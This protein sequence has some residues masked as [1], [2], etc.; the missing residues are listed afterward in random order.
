MR[1]LYLARALSGRASELISPALTQVK[2]T[3]TDLLNKSNFIGME[4]GARDSDKRGAHQ[5]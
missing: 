4:T 3:H 2:Q 1:W 5:N